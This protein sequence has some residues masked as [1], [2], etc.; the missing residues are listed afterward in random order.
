MFTVKCYGL[1]TVAAALGVVPF[2]TAQAS[3][4]GQLAIAPN[5]D[6]SNAVL[7]GYT[8]GTYSLTAIAARDRYGN[9]CIGY[10]DVNP[11]HVLV[12]QQ[13]FPRLTLDV[14]SGGNDTSLVVKGPGNTVRCAFG[15]KTQ[16]DAV[17]VDENWKAGKYRVWVGSLE[18]NRQFGYTLSALE[19]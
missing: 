3:N 1:L 16:P 6:S 10:S 19:E 2:V 4:F 18:A 5:F 12:L 11:D 14:E 7:R 15:S 17:L 13:N 9:A 8:G